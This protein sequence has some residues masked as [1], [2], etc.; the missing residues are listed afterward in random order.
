M[1]APPATPPS[2]DEDD[3]DISMGAAGGIELG[4]FAAAYMGSVSVKHPEGSDVCADAILRIK[5]KKQVDRIPEALNEAFMLYSKQLD[6]KRP[7]RAGSKKK[8]LAKA[9]AIKRE[10]RKSM[11]AVALG[12]YEARYL[13]SVAVNE[14][15]GNEVA[16]DAYQRIKNVIKSIPVMEISFTA[17]HPKDSK[18]MLVITNDARL[19]LKYCHAFQSR[20]SKGA[21]IL[22][23]IATA[24]AA[25]RQALEESQGNQDVMQELGVVVG[26]GAQSNALLSFAR[27]PSMASSG[28]RIGRRIAL[29]V[30]DAKYIGSVPVPELKGKP[31]VDHAL[32]VARSMNKYAEG[33]V[34]TISE[35]GVRTIEGLTG[36]VITSILISDISFCTTA[37]SKKEVFAF[38]NK[39]TR[40][41]RI[42]CHL[43]ETFNAHDITAV[44]GQAFKACQ[45]R[46]GNPFAPVSNE[47]ET[48]RGPLFE[49]QLHRSDL[50]AGKP[51]GAGQFGQVYLAKYKGNQV[52]VKTVRQGA[53]AED[54][55]AFS[56]GTG[57]P[58]SQLLMR[59]PP[60]THASS[61]CRCVNTAEFTA[62]SEVML[63][64]RHN[65]LVQLLGVSMQ[66]RP[67]LCVI[68]FMKYG[69][70]REVLKT[71]K[72]KSLRL[73][74][75][76]QLA[77]AV[78]ISRGMAFIA[79]QRYVHM[80]LAA[81]NVLI[82][83][84]NR[85]KVA[86]FGLTR[87]YDPG[88][89]TYTLR[90]TAKLPIR[91][92]AIE[93]MKTKVFS[94]KSDVWAFGVTLHEIA[95]YGALPYAG[96]KNRDVSKHILDG[97]RLAKPED[98]MQDDF[99]ALAESCWQDDP[100]V[101]PTF[102]EAT[103]SLEGFAVKARANSP[104]IRDI[105]AVLAS[106]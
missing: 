98:G 64:L 71:C 26:M 102:K 52:A 81:R 29:G 67:W 44:I 56:R 93:A 30:Y 21:E 76:E 13:G 106:M 99:F 33:V 28:G 50:I 88:K 3:L 87:R 7:G 75:L 9:A 15:R 16:L 46:A 80:D 8:A 91:W 89:D 23:M 103:K 48:V 69:D 105:G 40:L 70:L 49:H 66:Q 92:M 55:G 42:T 10:E 1:A 53:S 74:Y 36:E 27:F 68:E 17:V 100:A 31:V 82:S 5:V 11:K 79:Q 38:I 59:R 41:K 60:L 63:A 24:F 51:I 94:E 62:E 34:L 54:I 78:Q 39:D 86:D 18:M 6:S 97:N 95:A 96:V 14:P 65:C 35:E 83:E 32:H 84:G 101:R 4:N 20:R 37:G 12:T 104:T 57:L 61:F 45:A 90:K 77:F 22:E 2:A 43:Y 19:G 58:L 47:R 85:C 73:A 72:E 25:A